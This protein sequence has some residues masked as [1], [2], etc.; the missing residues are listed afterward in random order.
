M[1]FLRNTERSGIFH[2][3]EKSSAAVKPLSIGRTLSSSMMMAARSNL[4]SL[5][6]S[7]PHVCYKSNDSL[8]RQRGMYRLRSRRV[9]LCFFFSPKGSSSRI[10]NAVYSN[11]VAVYL[12]IPT[13]HIYGFGKDN[14]NSMVKKSFTSASDCRILLVFLLASHFL[15]LLPQKKLC[16][17]MD[18]RWIR[19]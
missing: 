15:P 5:E 12:N 2:Q 17:Q 18:Q 19:P 11:N 14:L 16:T 7:E 4:F 6:L 3:P 10:F 13:P 9:L 8:L 1:H